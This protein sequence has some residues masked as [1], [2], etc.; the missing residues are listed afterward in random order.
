MTDLINEIDIIGSIEPGTS[1]P[2]HSILTW[3]TNIDI[4]YKT[5]MQINNT[6][7]IEITKFS[8]D[9]PTNFLQDKRQGIR[10]FINRLEH[11]MHT[12]NEADENYVDF[13]HI[14]KQEMYQKVNYKNIKNKIGI[15]NKKRRTK[16]PWWSEELTV[17]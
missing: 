3:K 11:S 12:Q 5:D 13:I 2:D 8:R 4:I 14:I 15:N 1:K 6:K 7:H 16:K 17:I 9:I 10:N